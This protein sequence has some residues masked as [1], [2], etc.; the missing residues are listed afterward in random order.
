PA[1]IGE[2]FGLSD[3]DIDVLTGWLQSQGLRVDWVAPSRLFIGFSGTAAN[4]EQAFGAEIH[5]YAVNGEQRF[6][7]ASEPT[8]PQAVAPAIR[9]F[10]ACTRSKTDRCII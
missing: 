5:A 8:I 2:R 3:A 7:V 9:R 1:E 4:V 6:S 10:A